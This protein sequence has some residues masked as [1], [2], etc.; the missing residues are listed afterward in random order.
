MDDDFEEMLAMAEEEPD[1]Q[2]EEDQEAWE[3][4]Q[5]MEADV[6][7]QAAAP[8]T[9]ASGGGSGSGSTRTG[10]VVA[11]EAAH[12]RARTD[13]PRPLVHTDKVP[14]GLECE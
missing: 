1:W 12:Q 7:P 13:A 8:A 9:T 5:A 4:M 6:A 10:A 14:P 11:A 3:A 2:M